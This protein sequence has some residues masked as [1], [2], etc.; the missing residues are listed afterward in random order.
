MINVGIYIYDNAE[1]LDFSGPFEVF[2][3]ATRVL[4]KDLFNT[5]LINEIN[6]VVKARAN[7][8]TIP[9]YQIINHP[10]IDVL[11]IVGGDHSEEVNKPNVTQWILQQSKTAKLVAS[12]C[13]GAF[14]LAKANVIT[15]HEVTTHWDDISD[16]KAQYPK[17]KVQEGVRWVEHGN[18]ITSGGI[19]AGI[20][21]SL[22]IVSKLHS[23]DLAIATAK[24]MEFNW[25]RNTN[26][27]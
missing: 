4:K 8:K 9:D 7:Y 14:L 20:D 2:T 16:L 5:F 6:E 10:T 1:V 25:T 15:T 26:L 23:E 22:H 21:M 12:V 3:T 27:L 17:L 24:Q 18:I 13:T 11:I 19:S